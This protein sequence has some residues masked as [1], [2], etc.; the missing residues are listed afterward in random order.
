MVK[1]NV[2]VRYYLCWFCMCWLIIF[3][4]RICFVVVKNIGFC[5]IVCCLVK[6]K[7]NVW[8]Y[9]KLIIF[10]IL[11]VIWCIVCNV[12]LLKILILFLVMFK[13]CVI[14]VLILGVVKGSRW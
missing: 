12:D 4:F 11:L 9:S 10:G 1:I 5:I 7:V 6:D 3:L 2:D 14:Y 13:W 8:L